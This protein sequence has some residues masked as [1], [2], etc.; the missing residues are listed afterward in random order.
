MAWVIKEQSN[1]YLTKAEMQNNA[2]YVIEYMRRNGW[3]TNAIAALLG[4]L[5][6]ESHINPGCWQSGLVGVEKMGFGLCQWTPSTKY[7]SWAS[8][9]GYSRTNPTAQLYW[10]NYVMASSGE[11]IPTGQYNL[12]YNDFKTSTRSVSFLTAAWCYEFERPGKPKLPDRQ[13]YAA[14]WYSYITGGYV[15]P[16]PEP[17]P[18]PTDP[19][20]TPTPQPKP[21]T[22]GNT[23]L[24]F[25]CLRRF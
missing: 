6:K 16:T 13:A 15:P 9:N 2:N 3:T 12:S 1:W 10:I 25:L 22:G 23:K 18:T 8:K 4:N 17:D 5:Q 11:W 7:T 14:E 21:W 19:T 20:P 24:M